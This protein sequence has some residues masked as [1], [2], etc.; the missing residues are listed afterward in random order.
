MAGKERQLQVSVERCIGCRACA[1][2]CPAGL[3][4]LTDSHHRRTL[5]FV[6]M[7]AEECDLC[8]AACPTQAIRLAPLMGKPGEETTLNFV[9]DACTECGTPLAP[10]ETLAHLRATIPPQVQVDAEGKE[11]LVLC[12]ACRQQGEARRMGREVL[13]SRWMT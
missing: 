10:L 9:L 8:V 2:V 11:W 7:C 12:P 13:L 5:R 3:I 4:T 6:A 1:T